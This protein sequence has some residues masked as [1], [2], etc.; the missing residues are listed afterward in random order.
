MDR[1]W[2]LTWTTYGT[3]LSGDERG[4]VGRVRDDSGNSVIHNEPDTPCD[5]K[6]RGLRN[7]MQ[8]RMAGPV[9]LLSRNHAAPLLEQFQETARFRKWNLLACAIMANHIH[10]VVGVVGDPEPDTL[11]RDF[12]SYGSRRLNGDFTKPLSGT[13]WTSSG[14]TRKL[15]DDAAV[16]AAVKYVQNQSRPL[17]IWTADDRASGGA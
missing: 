2:L 4:F 6:Q 3:W 11:L 12:K 7:Y 8:E 9:V 10:M 5:A 17:L 14:S 1:V 15:P 16:L 13:W